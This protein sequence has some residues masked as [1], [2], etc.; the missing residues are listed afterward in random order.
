MPHIALISASVRTG[1]KSH[2]VA[3]HLQGVLKEGGNTVDLL[4][5]M[6]F[7]FPL[8]EERLK[9]MKDP[10]ANVV[11]FAD[12]VHK[13]DGVVIVTPEYNGT[14]PASLKNVLDLITDGWAKKP[15]AISTVSAG[16]FGGMQCITTLVHSFWK[17]KGWV[18]PALLPVPKV[19]EN[20]NEDGTPAIDPEGWARRTKAFV[21]ELGWAM[22]AR[23]RMQA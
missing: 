15:I 10:P 7:R 21:D 11:D 3:L 9:Y 22:E 20:F 12:R 5:L 23:R 6:E 4:D 17:I 1:R 16:A 8:F 19:G 2:R 13:A 18:V 14:V